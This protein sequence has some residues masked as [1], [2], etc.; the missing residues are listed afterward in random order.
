MWGR[1]PSAWPSAGGLYKK[2]C[3]LFAAVFPIILPLLPLCRIFISMLFAVVLVS[4]AFFAPRVGRLSFDTWWKAF[5]LSTPLPVLY[6]SIPILRAE[7][8]GL[9]YICLVVLTSSVTETSAYLIGRAMG[10][11]K[12]APHISPGKTA[13]FTLAFIAFLSPIL[14]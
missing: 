12:I 6:A 10:K 1:M 14:E 13:P 4:F 7:K 5:L 2:V 9:Y 11:Q 3:S 8:Y